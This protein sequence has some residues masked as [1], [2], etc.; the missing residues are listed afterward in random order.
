LVWSDGRNQLAHKVRNFRIFVLVVIGIAISSVILGELWSIPVAESKSS[1]TSSNKS[2]HSHGSSG[3]GSSIIGNLASANGISGTSSSKIGS[4]KVIMI[5]FDDSYKTQLLYAKPILDQYGFKAT[6]FEVCGWV[7]KTSERQTWQD[8]A[9]LQ[10]DGMDIE[11]HT[12]THAHLSSVS[13]SKLYY[14]LG[15]AKQCFAAHAAQGI[16]SLDTLII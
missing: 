2:S 14:E 9:T 11:S 7:G 1:V 4:N 6:F 5:N 10:Q 8:V 12:M 15:F 13:P 16:L 3:I